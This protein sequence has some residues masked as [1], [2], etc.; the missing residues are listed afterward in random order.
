MKLDF[1][2][3]EHYGQKYAAQVCDEFFNR[4]PTINGQQILKLSNVAQVN[5]F[6]VSDLFEKW[7]AD[8]EAFKSPYFNFDNDDVK[9]ALKAFMNMAS[10]HIMVKREHFEPMLSKAVVKT[11]ILL[12]DPSK[13]FDDFV[14]DSPEFTLTKERLAQLV[15]Y[16]K[17]NNH[18]AKSMAEKMA[19][20]DKV[21]VTVALSWLKEISDKVEFENADKF[22]EILSAKVPFR[23][24]DFIKATPK[25]VEEIPVKKAAQSFF[26]IEPEEDL[27]DENVPL[28]T[29]DKIQAE[30]DR[31]GT[32]AEIKLPGI[33][34]LNDTFTGDLPTVNDLLKRD[35]I[36][37]GTALSDLAFNR[38]IKSIADGVSLNQKFVFI[39]KLFDGDINAYSNA[40]D[41]IDACGN[42][43][44]AKNFM[45]KFLAPKYNWISVAEEAND[46]LEVVARKFQ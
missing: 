31:K 22:F 3:I 12:L 43:S 9:A 23:K 11:I 21:Y 29:V 41:K 26:D 8:T 30:I 19:G 7:K 17:I 35:S 6:V 28:P 4:T 14:R 18:I 32:P 42:L 10:Q 39:G 27:D 5:M 37:G 36:V 40:I 24:E 13:Y 34:R 25:P 1:S 2:A 15:K 45:N 33:D 38:P 16:T 20:D 44:D 46:F